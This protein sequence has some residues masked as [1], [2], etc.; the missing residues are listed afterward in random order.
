MPGLTLF[1]HLY[2]PGSWQ[3]LENKC[4][5]LIQRARRIIL[6]ACHD[7]VLNETRRPLD[8]AAGQVD[9]ITRLKVPNKGK[10][11]GGKL[12]AL[13]YYMHLCEKTDYIALLHDKISPQTINADYWSQQ[14]YGPFSE[15]GLDK[16]FRLLEQDS[17]VGILGSKAFLKNEFLPMENRFDTTNNDLLQQM[18]R[19]YHLHGRI[20]DFIAGTIFLGRSRIFENFFEKYSALESRAKLEPGNVLDLEKGTY[21]HSW[22]RLFCFIAEDQGYTIKG[23]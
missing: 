1:I 8:G 7:D 16:A 3:L 9:A 2:Y 17:R 14:L 19:Q 20:Y 23:I 6:T 12:A 15:E 21:A 4:A 5:A 10:D 11:I 22:E 18:I 13:S